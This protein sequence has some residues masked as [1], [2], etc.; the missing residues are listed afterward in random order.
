MNWADIGRRGC[1]GIA[2]GVLVA[3]AGCAMMEQAQAPALRTIAERMPQ[4][5]AGFVL[6][7]TAE[8]PGPSL[9]LD[10]ATPSRSAV[11]TVLVYD[12]A[13]E[14]APADPAAPAIDRELTAAVAELSEAPQGRTGRR[15]AERERMT[16]PDAGL[17]CAVMTGAFG[18]A[19][20][21]RQVCVGGAAGRFVKI[22]VTMADSRPRPA[23][24][25]AFAVA[26]IGAVRG[27]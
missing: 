2:A 10:Y 1:R 21:M 27:G 3:A 8:R 6:G 9:S 4:E 5:L 17:R 15:L 12:G 13:G 25:N 16:L 7:E 11:G 14:R 20:V 23:D 24:A 19:P 26:A 18:R 22:Q